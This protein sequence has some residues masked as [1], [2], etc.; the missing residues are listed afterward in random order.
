MEIENVRKEKTI[1]K[2][3]D[4]QC[5]TTPSCSIDGRTKNPEEVRKG[6]D[7]PED[8]HKCTME[9]L[10]RI[11]ELYSKKNDMKSQKNSK[12]RNGDDY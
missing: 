10:L 3:L 12:G 8:A 6:L 5:S 2:R 4:E 11:K 7:V 9:I 1:K